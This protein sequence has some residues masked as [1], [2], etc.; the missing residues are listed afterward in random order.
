MRDG[1]FLETS[2]GSPNYA[3]PEVIAGKCYAGPEIDV[4]SCGVILYVMLCGQLPFDDESIP[5]LF[6]KIQG[7]F[8]FL[9]FIKS[10]LNKI[11]K[12]IRRNFYTSVLPK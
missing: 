7:T 8:C 9:F 4:W 3:S 11:F 2:C 1:D 5:H 12:T 6:Q 10:F